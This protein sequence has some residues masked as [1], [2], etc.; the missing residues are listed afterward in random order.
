MHFGRVGLAAL[1]AWAVFLALGFLIHSVMLA[2]MWQ[3]LQQTGAARSASAARPLMPIGY[4][5]ALVGALAFAYAYAKGYEGGPGLQEGMRFGVLVGLIL[6]AFGLAW[7][8][9]TFPLPFQYLTWMAVATVIQFA[10]IG[11]TVGLIYRH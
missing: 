5:L 10:G 7:N 2:D 6:V 11:M 1:A 9:V 8:Y 4:G 3:G